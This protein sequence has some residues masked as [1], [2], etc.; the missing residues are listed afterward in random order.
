MLDKMKNN[1]LVLLTL[2]SF[3]LFGCIDQKEF[4]SNNESQILTLSLSGQSGSTKIVNATNEIRITV[5]TSANLDSLIVQDLVLSTFASANI[6]K[7]DRIQIADSTFIITVSAE[8]KSQTTYK[9]IVQK[10]GANPQIAESNFDSWYTT[11][12]GYQEPGADPTSTLWA[13]GNPGTVTLGSANVTPLTIAGS[14]IAAKLVTLDLGNLAGLVNQRMG[15]GSMFTGKFELDISNPLNSTKFGVPFGG[16][17]IGFSC[18]YAYQPGTPYLNNKGIAQAKSDSCDVYVLLEHRTA[19]EVKRVGTAWYRSGD[20][21]IDKFYNLNIPIT[22]GIL[23]ADV[24]SYMK[25]ANGLYAEP[26]EQITHIT[27]VFSSSYNGALFE[28][29]TNSTLVV[30]NFKLLY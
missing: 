26:N 18:D 30:N 9:L 29:G 5:N 1:C 17:P 6:Q 15:A 27:V 12:K 13:T 24:P 23:A 19:S 25:P 22:Y 7:G 16:K 28:G 3:L 10:E 11:P 8:D 14:D 4:G 2:S 20:T 21:K